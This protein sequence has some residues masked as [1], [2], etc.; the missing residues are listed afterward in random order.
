MLLEHQKRRAT[1]YK[2]TSFSPHFPRTNTLRQASLPVW[3]VILSPVQGGT[4]SSLL[5]NMFYY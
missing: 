3:C 4:V 2:S 1:T 5:C